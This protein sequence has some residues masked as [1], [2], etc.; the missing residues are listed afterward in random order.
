MSQPGLAGLLDYVE[1]GCEECEEVAE[2]H[3]GMQSSGGEHCLG[4]G[5]GFW[6]AETTWLAGAGIGELVGGLD[7]L[8]SRLEHGVIGAGCYAAG[9]VFSCDRRWAGPGADGANGGVGSGL[10]PVRAG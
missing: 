4:P 3:S 5:L 1:D 9:C 7:W 8:Y 6:L 10:D 2:G